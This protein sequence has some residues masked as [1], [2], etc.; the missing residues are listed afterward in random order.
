MDKVRRLEAALEGTFGDKRLKILNEMIR[1]RIH[2]SAEK[3]IKYCEEAVVVQQKCTLINDRISTFRLVAGAYLGIGDNDNALKNI[4]I[5]IEMAEECGDYDQ[6]LLVKT[7]QSEFFLR[8]SEFAEA[9]EVLEGFSDKINEVDDRNNVGSFLNHLGIAYDGLGKFDSALEIYFRVLKEIVLQEKND[10]CCATHINIGNTFVNCQELEKAIHH[11]NEAMEIAEEMNNERQKCT[12]AFNIAGIFYYKGE[13]EKAL[14][15]Y[16]KIEQSFK[17][18]GHMADLQDVICN[19]GRIYAKL[20]KF[21]PAISYLENALAISEKLDNKYV[22]ANTS[23]FLAE[24]YFEQKKFDQGEILLS[25]ALKIAE[26]I[27]AQN[28]IRG[29]YETKTDY[30]KSTRKYKQALQYTEKLYALTIKVFNEESQKRIEE[31]QVQY[32]TDKKEHEAEIYR[33]KNVELAESNQKLIE[34]LDQVKVLGGLIPICATCKKIRDDKGFWNQLEAYITEHSDASFTH[35]ICPSCAD[36][37]YQKLEG[38]TRIS[39][40]G[41]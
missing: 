13:Y 9:I 31:L 39:I 4:S 14:D 5:A 16:K 18:Q 7:I 11:Y 22:T 1:A 17:D 40:L 26:D 25:R 36:E 29:I 24:L 28:L 20:G 10:L 33:L 15:Y 35:G 19:I 2:F 34:A 27:N 37:V 3:T 32:E 23:R 8:K 6:I 21:K 12:C 38:M 30:Y 41:R